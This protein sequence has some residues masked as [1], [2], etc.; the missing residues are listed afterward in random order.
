MENEVQEIDLRQLLQVVL[1]KWWLIAIF[2]VIG[3]VGSFVF[4][5]YCMEPVYN[6][7]TSLFIGKEKGSLG[8]ISLGDLNLNSKLIA[9]YRELSKSRLVVDEVIKN[10]DLNMSVAA[11]RK[12]LSVQTVKD[13]RLFTINFQHTNPELAKDVANEIAS[14]LVEQASIIIEVK[15]IQV[16]DEALV[17]EHPIKPNKKMNV[18]IAGILSIMIA[19]FVIIM[20][21]FMDNTFKCEEDIERELGLTVI[22]VIPKF[23]GEDR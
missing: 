7:E 3:T 22:G 16:V 21:E 13:S 20:I 18:A 6:A 23:E 19:L 17:P 2:A 5:S 14:I 10:L 11:F 8:S 4:T 15:N 1:A 12:N 9:D